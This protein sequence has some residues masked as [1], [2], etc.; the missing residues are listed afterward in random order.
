MYPTAWRYLRKALGASQT[1]HH[2]MT[3]H[4]HAQIS[5]SLLLGSLSLCL[6]IILFCSIQ[7][8]CLP[9]YSE[10]GLCRRSTSSSLHPR[11]C[12]TQSLPVSSPE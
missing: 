9:P 5:A 6:F 10:A 1:P 4:R 7:E 8:S 12:L 11:A 3:T 2:Q